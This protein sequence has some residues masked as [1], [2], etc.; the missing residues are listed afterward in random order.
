MVLL[1]YELRYI[2]WKYKDCN[3]I[4]TCISDYNNIVTSSRAVNADEKK[5][6]IKSDSVHLQ[7]D[8]SYCSQY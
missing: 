1:S 5:N 2:F 6:L 8:I 4:V 3:I 7:L